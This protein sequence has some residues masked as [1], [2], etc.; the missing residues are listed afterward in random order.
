MI[1]WRGRFRGKARAENECSTE[2]E[3]GGVGQNPVVTSQSADLGSWV[4]RLMYRIWL[5]LCVLDIV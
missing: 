1:Y 4:V 2:R 3:N 5:C